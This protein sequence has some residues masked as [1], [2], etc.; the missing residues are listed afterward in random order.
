MFPL[1]TAIVFASAAVVLLVLNARLWFFGDEFAYL[2]LSEY[3]HD[4]YLANLF[5]LHNEHPIVWTKLWFQALLPLVG[6]KAYWPYAIPLIIAHL[7][8]A[9]FVMGIVRRW[10]GQRWVALAAA[11]V[12]LFAG[13]GAED[14]LWAGQIQFVLP[15]ALFVLWIWIFAADRFPASTPQS[16]ALALLFGIV[17]I[18]SSLTFLPLAVGMGAAALLRKRALVATLITATPLAIWV[19]LVRIYGLPPN[20]QPPLGSVAARLLDLAVTVWAFLVSPFVDTTGSAVAGYALLGAAILVLVATIVRRDWRS[21]VLPLWLGALCFSVMVG[22][23]RY[24]A[25]EVGAVASR[26]QYIVYICL[27][28][29]LAIGGGQL[30]RIAGRARARPV[31]WMAGALVAATSLALVV[32]GI[33]QLSEFFRYA[34]HLRNDLT[35]PVIVA[36]ADAIRQDRLPGANPNAQV[37]PRFDPDLR[38]RR[39]EYLVD[40]GL[41]P[42]G[43]APRWARQRLL[44][45]IY[46]SADAV[47]EPVP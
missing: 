5:A 34:S 30:L 7:L 44:E 39:L 1:A 3:G 29:V 15:T 20:Q 4:S 37:E 9:A 10:T 11:A 45:N 31:E 13:C 22:L 19:L 16:I 23:G 27:V 46:G 43:P 21:P 8:V 38:L 40:A 14:L 12:V 17:G 24:S 2:D 26:H 25:A 47:P 35:K 33:L 36:G 6:L 32:G 41:M 28:P 18:L 42:H